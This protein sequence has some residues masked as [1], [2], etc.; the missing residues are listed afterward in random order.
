[1][2]MC[3]KRERAHEGWSIWCEMLVM[4][5]GGRHTMFFILCLFL[6]PWDKFE[7]SSKRKILEIKKNELTSGD[8]MFCIPARVFTE[9]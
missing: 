6:Q 1:M 3:V 8:Q 7:I 5:V 4:G 9:P 2:P